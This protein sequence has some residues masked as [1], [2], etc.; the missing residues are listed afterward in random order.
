MKKLS[1]KITYSILAIMNLNACVKHLSAKNII[2]ELK[3]MIYLLNKIGI[4][5]INNKKKGKGI[6]IIVNLLFWFWFP[7]HVL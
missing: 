1:Q 4:I 2:H 7:I 6:K 3:A 5:C